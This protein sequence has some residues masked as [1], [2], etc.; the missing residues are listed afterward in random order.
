MNWSQTRE[1]L[2]AIADDILKKFKL[3]IEGKKPLDEHVNGP[4]T[5][6]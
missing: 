2:N 5:R 3:A 1:A 6:N 4:A